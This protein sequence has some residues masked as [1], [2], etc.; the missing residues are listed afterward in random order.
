MLGCKF[1]FERRIPNLSL[2]IAAMGPLN[3]L[4]T[5]KAAAIEKNDLLPPLHRVKGN[6]KNEMRD[7]ADSGTFFATENQL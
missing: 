7:I 2:L 1:T 3:N 5:K 6:I 4:R